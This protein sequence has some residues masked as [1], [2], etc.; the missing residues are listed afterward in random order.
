MDFGI[1]DSIALN[2]FSFLPV[3]RSLQSFT[4][5]SLVLVDLDNAGESMGWGWVMWAAEGAQQEDEG[6]SASS[7]MSEW[8]LPCCTPSTPRPSL[9]LRA[10][11]SV[12]RGW[13]GEPAAVP[14]LPISQS[15]KALQ[16]CDVIN[17]GRCQNMSNPAVPGVAKVSSAQGQGGG[18]VAALLVL[19]ESPTL[20][21]WTV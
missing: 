4:K 20:C 5:Q 15:H 16:K 11:C 18:K 21:Q 19:D 10:A 13:A 7:D 14:N 3:S 6:N 9:I 8:V 17:W 1:Q 2:C 12:L